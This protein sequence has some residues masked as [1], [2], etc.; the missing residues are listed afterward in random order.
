MKTL[1]MVC[2]AVGLV[3]VIGGTASGSKIVT[4]TPVSGAVLP[5]D[6][7]GSG[8]V[9]LQFDLSGLKLDPGR[10]IGLAIVEVTV[11]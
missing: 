3:S 7:D 2:L 11:L 1:T 4:L 6:F 5:A 8:R 10:K 9:A